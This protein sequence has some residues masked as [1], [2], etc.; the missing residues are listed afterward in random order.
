[1]NTIKIPTGWRRRE[2]SELVAVGDRAIEI[3]GLR[4]GYTHP[5]AEQHCYVLSF[6]VK[7]ARETLARDFACSDIVV[8]TR[9]EA[10]EK[11][12]SDAVPKCERKPTLKKIKGVYCYR[13]LIGTI[14]RGGDLN[15]DGSPEE[16]KNRLGEAR[17]D[18]IDEDFGGLWRPLTV[19]EGYRIRDLD[20]KIAATD[21]GATLKQGVF[22]L[23]S[24]E[25]ACADIFNTVRECVARITKHPDPDGAEDFVLLEDLRAKAQPVI[26][27]PEGFRFLRDDEKLAPFASTAKWNGRVRRDGSL[28]GWFGPFSGGSHSETMADFRKAVLSAQPDLSEVFVA[29]PV[30]VAKPVDPRDAKIAELEKV[31]AE[32]LDQIANLDARLGKAKEAA[33]AIQEA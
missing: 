16:L 3:G 27:P 7:T 4:E 29:V 24:A 14:V 9:E 21:Y 17:V 12:V 31:I 8:I 20:E 25:G 33:L 23:L 32:Q 5:D 1:M 11:A 13:L 6:T 19:P 15:D 22:T 18:S 2:D 26:N 30:E 28:R 10:P